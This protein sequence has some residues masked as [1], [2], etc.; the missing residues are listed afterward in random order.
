[1]RQNKLWVLADKMI[2][3]EMGGKRVVKIN[4][5]MKIANIKRG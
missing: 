2:Q 4:L 5:V 3:G 1:M